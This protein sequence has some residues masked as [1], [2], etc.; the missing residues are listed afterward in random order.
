MAHVLFFSFKK[1][2]HARAR[3]KN[4]TKNTFRVDGRFERFPLAFSDHN[5][6]ASA[7]RRRGKGEEEK[8]K[9]MSDKTTQTAQQRSCSSSSYR[10]RREPRA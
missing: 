2:T 7:A 8:L 4:K 9:L 3:K 6:A 1:Q 5:V 10:T